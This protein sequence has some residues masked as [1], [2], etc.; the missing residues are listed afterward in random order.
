[1]ANRQLFWPG[2]E[3]RTL[4]G[5]FYL[6][7]SLSEAMNVIFPFQFI[8]LY[9]VME[10]PEWA[11]LP[12]L[13]ETVTVWLM[14]IPTGI[15]ADRWGR[16][17]SVISGDLLSAIS[18]VIIPL[19]V[20]FRGPAQLYMV[21]ACFFLEGIGQT[22]VSGAE[23]AW[24]VDN[25][26]SAGREDLMEQYFARIRSFS[27]LGGVIAGSLSLL[28][29]L[30]SRVDRSTLNF[31]WY[32]AACGQ[33]ISVAISLTIPEHQPEG[34]QPDYDQDEADELEMAPFLDRARQGFSAIFQFRPLFS[35]FLALCVT[36]FAGSITGEAFEISLLTKGLDA[37]GLAPLG[38]IGDLTGMVVPLWGVA[39]SQWL[40]STASL[41]LFVLVPAGVVSLFFARPGLLLV[42]GLYLIFS[43]VDDL[44]DPVADARL[45]SL[46]PSSCRATAGSITNQAT[47]LA[48]SAGI[49]AFALLLGKHSRELR[50]ATPDLMEAFSG[51]ASTRPK[52]PK[53]LFGLPVPDLAL[54]LFTFFG[55][56]AIPFLVHSQRSGCQ[57]EEIMSRRAKS[58]C[59][60][61]RSRCQEKTS[62]C[63]EEEI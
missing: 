63:Q 45:Q 49:G 48:N 28:L 18:W 59:Q 17:L 32:I 2:R 39:I 42:V 21:C 51:G 20:S 23:D 34:D 60:E 30:V 24:V 13:V 62:N 10:W 47:E 11:I 61:K 6:A 19:A 57:D 44:W 7:S 56:A 14:E 1:M 16:K 52:V 25:L 27:S 9:L 12:T 55:L 36:S 31:L 43:I 41:V 5:R 38:V 50:E 58:T 8:Y 53:G 35:F 40:G 22:L 4:V 33:L 26:A 3:E 29:L 15:V 46:I 37:R 54:V